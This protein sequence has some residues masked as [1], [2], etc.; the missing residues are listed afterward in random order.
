MQHQRD[1]DR[2]A[3]GIGFLTAKIAERPSLDDLAAHLGMSAFHTQRLFKRY[4]GVTPKQFLAAL[5]LE[6]A[7]DL[8]ARNVSVLDAA[9]ELGLSGPARLHDH[10]VTLEAVTPGEFK[11]GGTDVTIRYGIAATPFGRMIVGSTDRGICCLQFTNDK[12]AQSVLRAAWPNAELQRDDA[13]PAP[14]LSRLFERGENSIRVQVAGTNFQ[15]R[16]WQALLRIPRGST[17]S[18]ADVANAVGE[19]TA[20]RAVGNAV[21]ANPIAVLIPCHRVITGTG[22]IGDYRWGSDRKRSL[23]AW[24]AATN[25]ALAAG[26]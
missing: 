12:S 2:I 14:V 9:F 11:S 20:A 5:T 10:F 17:A 6:R 22:A 26:A 15:V 16:V 4:A 3:D 1:Y 21:A 19:P 23:L 18:Y 13:V 24:E 8:L 7:K 25:T